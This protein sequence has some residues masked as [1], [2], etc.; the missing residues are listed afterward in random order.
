MFD[1]TGRLGNKMPMTSYAGNNAL[2]GVAGNFGGGGWQGFDKEQFRGMR[3]DMPMQPPMQ[4]AMQPPGMP[5]Q[6]QSALAGYGG[7]GPMPFNP[8]GLPQ[9][10]QDFRQQMTDWRGMRPD[11][12]DFGAMRG[13]EGFDPAA[14]QAARQD[15]RGQVR[16]WRDTRPQFNGWR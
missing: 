2:A 11:R 7:A 6:A 8:Q 1:P 12:P 13:Q 14:M 10:F 5:V 16:D 15:W 4:P 9:Q 3:P